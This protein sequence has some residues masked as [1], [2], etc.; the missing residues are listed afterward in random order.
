M[1]FSDYTVSV[2]NGVGIVCSKGISCTHGY[3][4]RLGGVSEKPFDTLNLGWN[5]A[6]PTE[7]VAKNYE[8]LC[9]AYNLDIN[10]LILV[11]YKHGSNVLAVDKSSCGRGI[12]L[13]PL[14]ECDGLVTND[15]SVVLTTLHADCACL[16]VYNEVAQCIGIAHAG[17][18]GIFSRI[19]ARLVEKMAAQYNSKP[20]NVKVAISP[21]ICENCYEVDRDLANEFVKEFRTKDLILPHKNEDKAYLNLRLAGELQFLECGVQK[22]SINHISCCTYENKTLFYSYRRDG[23]NAGANAGFITLRSS[24]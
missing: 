9:D 13:E 21:C 2:K 23:N 11:N 19:G 5:R 22:Q 8:L 12:S 18:R 10:S 24:T 3:T 4:T 1:T 7:T 16:F 14:P 6:E 15:P 17:W 20:C